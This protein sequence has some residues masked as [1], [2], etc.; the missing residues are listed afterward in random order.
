MNP[1]TQAAAGRKVLLGHDWLTGMR[2]G[3][4]VLQCHCE[5]FPDAP[6]VALFG[7]LSKVSETI[8]SHP[9]VF[10]S[11]QHLPQVT[12]YYRHLLPIMGPVAR[13]VALPPGD[14]LLTT[15]HCVA[16]SFRKRP[17]MRHLCYCFTPM[18][19]AWLFHKEYLGTVKACLAAPLLAHL[20]HWDRETSAGVDRFV[21]ISRHVQERILRF[22]GRASDV[23]HP[24]VDTV[25]YTPSPQATAAGDYDLIVSALVPYKR[26]DLAIRAYRTIPRKLK[27]VGTGTETAKLRVL[28]GDNVEF[29]GWRGDDDVRELYRNC[30]MLLFPGEE[31]FGIVPLEAMACGRPVVAFRRGGVT[32]T[33]VEG[34]SGIFFD[35]QSVE[36]LTQAVER[37]ARMPWERGAIRAHAE[38]FGVARFLSEMAVCVERTLAQK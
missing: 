5:A 29:L 32:E 31:D 21:A 8:R 19:Y 12:R 1:L 22:Y 14:L 18:R 33:V 10:S 35:D 16:K 17:G 6:I 11:L 30:H 37:A 27:I 3:E 4:R 36:S 28:A 9:M 34:M 7:D 20:R 38:T 13:A 23:V 26:I 2:G 15:S 25:R 24:P